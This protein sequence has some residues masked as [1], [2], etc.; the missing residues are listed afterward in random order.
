MNIERV[1]AS[2]DLPTEARVDQRIPKKLLIENMAP[3]AADKR[4]INEG[5]EE[6]VWVATL[7]PNTIGVPEYKDSEREILEIAVL[8]LLLR[9][10]AKAT[11]IV[12]LIHRAIP[13]PLLLVSYQKDVVSVSLATKRWAQNEGSKTVLDDDLL[14]IN[15]ADDE[16][17]NAFLQALSL[18]LQPRANLNTFYMGWKVAI[19]AYRASTFVGQFNIIHKPEAVETRRAALAVADSIQKE[20]VTLKAQAQRET[21]MNRRVELNLEIKKLETRLSEAKQQMA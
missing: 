17:T 7:K 11:R 19:E 9:E 12:E 2:L 13:Y 10:N 16:V 18:K 3:T 14:V 4:Q 8:S 15:L 21:Q 6:L 20:L 1:L 5:I